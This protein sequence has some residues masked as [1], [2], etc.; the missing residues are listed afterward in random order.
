MFLSD[1]SGSAGVS[2]GFDPCGGEYIGDTAD[3]GSS[4]TTCAVDWDRDGVLD[5]DEPRPANLIEQ[6]MVMQCTLAGG[7]MASFE[8]VQASDVLDKDSLDDDDDPYTN[9]AE[10]LGG[11]SGDEDEEAYLEVSLAGGASYVIVV[12]AGTDTGPYELRVR[13]LD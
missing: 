13:Q 7:D 6:V 1:D 8:P 3:S 4:E 12:G 5:L 10:N 11:R 9:R 2:G